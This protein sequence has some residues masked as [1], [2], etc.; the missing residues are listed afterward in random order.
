MPINLIIFLIIATTVRLVLALLFPLTADESYYWLWS[1]HLA[2]SYVDHP[3]VVAYLNFLFTLGQPT[4]FGLRLGA[5]F[6]FLLISLGL[7]FLARKIF[8]RTVA[9]WSVVLFQLIPHYL[10]VWLTMFVEL[11]LGLFWIVSLWLLARIV[12]SKEAIWWYWLGLAVGLGYLSKYTMFL[13]WPCLLLFFYLAPAERF[14]LKRKEPYLSLILSLILF[15]PVLAWNAQHG[16]VSFL[17]HEAK[18]SSDAWGTSVLPFIGD[19]LVHFTPFLLFALWP[20]FRYA[21]KKDDGSR[22]L[23]SFS[24]PLLLLFL[25]L[26]FCFQSIQLCLL[27]CV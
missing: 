19:Q 10:I 8:N 21:L 9:A 11:P 2:L 16:W 5:A 27:F 7:F 3:P 22:L 23:F 4:I 24:F 6:I 1:K 26:S 13:F 12:K 14:W 15:L 20:V 17:F 18:I 25:L